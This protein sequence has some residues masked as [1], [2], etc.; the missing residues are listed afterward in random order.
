MKATH[1]VLILG[2]SG[3]LTERLLLPGIGSLISS[4]LAADNELVRD[5]RILGTGRTERSRAEWR[6][7]VRAA[8]K[9]VAA[10]GARATAVIAE[11]DYVAGDPTSTDHLNDL[12]SRAEGQLVIY[13]ALPPAIV[14]RV[15]DAIAKVTLPPDTVLAFEKPFGSDEH[16]A[17]KLNQQLLKIVREEQ[18]HRVDHFLG[19]AT[20]L[21]VLGLRLVNRLVEPIWNADNIEKVEIIYDEDL[22]LENR[23]GYYDNAGAL[24]DMLQSHLLQVMAVV[25]MEPPAAIDAIDFRSAAAQV[26]RATTLWQ[27]EPALPGTSGNSRRARYT[28]GTLGGKKLPSYASEDGVDASR[29]TETLAEIVVAV[30]T[31][32]WAGVP[33]ILRSGKALTEPK[34]Q[35][36]VTLRPVGQVPGGLVGAESPERIVIGL[37]PAT[38]SFEMTMN[39]DDDPF[40]LESHALT[41]TLSTNAITAYGEVMRGVLGGDPTLS[42]RGDV[43]EAC[44][45]VVAPALSAW[46]ANTVPLDEYAAGSAG[47][48]SWDS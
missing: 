10:S 35:I 26:L 40:Q 33:F 25:A 45:R 31:R 42:I 30:N 27:G 4:N 16:N 39:G 47:P 14:E 21:G 22:A 37:K 44:W 19:M 29:G 38:V 43:A 9:T 41:T 20:V 12:I 13:F 36:I 23:A 5:V 2:A 7:T 46:R 24:V 1:T 34:K 17:A 48:R 8:F 6:K 11:A 18:I 32:R 28:A 15:V 3:D